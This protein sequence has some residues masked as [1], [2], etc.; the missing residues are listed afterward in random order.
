[1]ARNGYCGRILQLGIKA[2]ASW[3]ACL[4]LAVA[5]TTGQH[6]RPEEMLP[7]DAVEAT[8]PQQMLDTYAAGSAVPGSWLRGFRCSEEWPAVVAHAERRL[9]ELGYKPVQAD[10]FPGIADKQLSNDD[11]I[12]YY[13]S[14]DGRFQVG[15]VN[16]RKMREAHLQL[17]DAESQNA[18]QAYAPESI[19]DYFIYSSAYS[20]N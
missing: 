19:A 9:T 2:A 6:I 17:F 4:G 5:C 15:I 13:D 10:P 1:M 8:P 16:L 3:L 7:P 18:S 11:V 12:R 14:P 20:E